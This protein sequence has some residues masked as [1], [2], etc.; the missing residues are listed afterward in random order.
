[1]GTL[2]WAVGRASSLFAL[3]SG[4]WASGRC[5]GAEV[6]LWKFQKTGFLGRKKGQGAWCGWKLERGVMLPTTP[7][8]CF[9]LQI[10]LSKALG[11][12]LK[13]PR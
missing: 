11:P 5:P 12:S 4:S 2:P 9:L 13:V 6:L 3:L 1:M 10:Q 7:P 8:T